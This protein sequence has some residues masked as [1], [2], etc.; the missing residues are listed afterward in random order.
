[1]PPIVRKVLSLTRCN[2]TAADSVIN[3]QCGPL[4]EESDDRRESVHR[5]LRRRIDSYFKPKQGIRKW[6]TRRD[7]CLT[8]FP[9]PSMMSSGRH[10]SHRKTCEFGTTH[11]S[12]STTIRFQTVVGD[13]DVFSLTPHAI[14]SWNT[15]SAAASKNCFDKRASC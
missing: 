13:E 11:R 7:G 5:R 6:A 2:H 10:L 15:R 3:Q 14:A 8:H 9:I 4:I 12:E 1:M